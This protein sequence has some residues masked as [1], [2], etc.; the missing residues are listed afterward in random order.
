MMAVKNF[1]FPVLLFLLGCLVSCSNSSMYSSSDDGKVQFEAPREMVYVAAHG[2]S[3]FLG[4]SAEGASVKESPA[5]RVNFTYDFAM[6]KSEVTR[7]E[8]YKLL[9]RSADAFVDDSLPVTSVTYFDAILFA[10]AKSRSESLDT[11]YTYTAAQFDSLGNC[12][13]LEGLEFHPEVQAYRLPTE[14][15]WVFAA[16]DGW[17]VENSWSGGNSGYE[18]H[19]VC[20]RE[21]NGLG[22]CDME[23][24]VVEWVQDWFSY[25]AD[26]V[27]TNFVGGKDGGRLGE[28]IVKGG[29]YG[30]DP[31]HVSVVSR[32]DVYTVFSANRY[33]HLGFR[34]CYGSIPDAEWSGQSSADA[35]SNIKVVAS[36]TS[37][38]PITGTFN[39]RLAFRNDMTGNLVLVNFA[40]DGQTYFE[41]QDTIDVYHPEI[42]PDGNWV[43]FCTQYE[44]ASGKSSLYVRSMNEDSTRVFRLEVESAAIP[45][46]RILPSGDTVIVYVTNAGINSDETV[47]N[48]ASTWQVA[49][50]GGKFKKPEKLFD[51]AYRDGVS[52]ENSLAVSGA[53]L[54]RV[55][56]DGKDTVW[57]DGAQACNASLSGDGSNRVLFLDF[58]GAIGKEIVGQKYGTHGYVL[59]ADST[60]ALV[61]YAKAPDGYAFDHTEWAYKS[62]LVVATL[63]NV[64]G[65]HS[66]IVLVDLS[67]NKVTDL[68]TGTEIWHPSFWMQKIESSGNGEFVLN[69][70]SAG[71]Y[72]V[73]NGSSA[74]SILREKMEMFWRYRDSVNLIILGS[75]RP[76]SGLDP[77]VFSDSI[78]AFNMS[79]IP[80]NMELNRFLFEN[81]VLNHMSRLK[82][83]VVSLDIDLWWRTE[84]DVDSYFFAYEYKSYPGFVYDENHDFWKDGYP[85]N[86]LEYTENNLYVALDKTVHSK[87]RG[88]QWLLSGMGWFED[89]PV[90]HDS[91]W[92]DTYPQYYKKNL[93]ALKRLIGLAKLHDVNV[94][95]IVF[96]QSPGYRKTG[97]FG[98]YG[99]RR[100]EADS[101][102][103]ELK[104]LEN[105]YGNFRFMDENKMGLHDYP[106][107]LAYNQDHLLNE[108]AAIMVP[109][110]EKVLKQFSR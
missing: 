65:A 32:S 43:A 9:K 106:D 103:N 101:L 23:G 7:G 76:S 85:E 93:E 56:V 35:L 63:T 50:S 42:S 3:V 36:G 104:D 96:P 33:A 16:S 54:L 40:A 88:M 84:D 24:N 98:R 75:S 73:E 87:N 61:Q 51:G 79:C 12:M 62:G 66:R 6:G 78:F 26:T 95:G 72:Y 19:K 86:L 70:D 47:W 48:E 107:S 99:I 102:L 29:Y 60:G 31:Q 80:D 53:R 94:V 1:V 25:F 69:P 45:R 58:D 68:V 74:A 4:T 64:N 38:R 90:E 71:V 41:I 44:G 77:F 2:K 82:Y 39:M 13:S 17:N 57:F 28:R 10:N 91:T 21:K 11:A 15:E 37:L 49:W 59:V 97:S 14:A 5:M 108:A 105:V 55:R 92:L 109:R 46:W 81:Y 110:I 100:S 27:Y 34:L 22:L 83:V 52:S 67:T 18:M 20:S 30:S 8:F 89:P